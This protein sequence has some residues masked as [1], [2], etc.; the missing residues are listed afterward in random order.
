MP[1]KRVTF[2][3]DDELDKKIRSL[4]VGLIT[5]TNE[6]IDLAAE[7]F[8]TRQAHIPPRILRMLAIFA[9]HIYKAEMACCAKFIPQSGEWF[10]REDATLKTDEAA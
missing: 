7:R 2:T 10:V 8:A 9:L 3:L 1:K 6:S 5:T 4:Q